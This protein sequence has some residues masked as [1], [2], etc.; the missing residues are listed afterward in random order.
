MVQ[1]EPPRREQIVAVV[2]V[3]LE[4]LPDQREA[5]RVDA[6]RREPDDAVAGGDVCAVDEA[7]ALDQADA[8]PGEVELV[9]AVDPG[10]SAVSPPTRAQPAERQHLGGAVD[11]LRHLLEVD[12]VFAAK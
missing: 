5:V 11:Q 9:V 1:V 10:S 4:D 7:I 6:R 3:Q 2:V 8:G 12:A